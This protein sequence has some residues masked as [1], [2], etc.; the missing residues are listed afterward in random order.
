M[1]AR[2][3]G[4]RAGEALAVLRAALT[5][6]LVFLGYGLLKPLRDEIATTRQT[7][8]SDLW[9][10]TLFLALLATP[11][12][13]WLAART[14]RRVL[15][16]RVYVF[17]ALVFLG[18][19]PLLHNLDPAGTGRL[20]T[21]RAFYVWVSTYNL[22]VISLVWSLA[23]EAFRS[24]QSKRIFGLIAAGVSLGL[25][26]GNSVTAF[27]AKQLDVQGLLL[28][29]AVSLLLAAACARGI[30]PHTAETPV[31][32]A[33]R[34]GGSWWSGLRDLVRDPYLRA[35]TIYL[36]LYLVGSGFI[37][38]LKN[39]LIADAFADRAV[40]RAFLAR[41]DLITNSCT[42]LLQLLVTG[43]WLPRFGVAATLAIV[44]LVTFAGFGLLAA[45]PV[46]LVIVG[47]E[48]TRRVSEFAM[49]KPAREVLFTVGGRSGRFQSKPILDTLVYRGADMGV[50]KG[51]EALQEAGWAV[52][53]LA[54][55]VLPFAA[56]GALVA[57]L[58]GRMYDK[59]AAAA[60][61]ATLSS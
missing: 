5:G 53:G 42:L 32:A 2:L 30:I 16:P 55:F 22:F 38:I 41:V 29:A 57:W 6:Y 14:S 45:V 43:R 7:D 11:I 44:P 20:W 60:E 37:Y 25:V 58:L 28:I 21:D 24:E 47:F 54:L 26:S 17:F 61:N 40:K 27:L 56:A 23:A 10:G 33:E 46:L 13:G 50:A 9:T 31:A 4:L 59:R 19:W 36:L 35:V 8:I 34:V 15:V 12:Y 48:V 49:S 1:L 18:F 52:R 3:L 51:C 39:E